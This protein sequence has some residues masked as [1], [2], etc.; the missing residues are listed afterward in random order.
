MAPEQ[1]AGNATAV[2][3]RADVY[4]LGAILYELLTG[5]PPFTGVTPAETML[6]LLQEYAILGDLAERLPVGGAGNTEP[7]RQ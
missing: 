5:R 4:A 7:D 2:G 6:Q 3:P 1:A